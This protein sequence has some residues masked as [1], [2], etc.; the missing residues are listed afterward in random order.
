MAIAW[1]RKN[2]NRKIEAV[3]AQMNFF[4]IMRVFLHP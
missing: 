4:D 3:K 2:E 1:G